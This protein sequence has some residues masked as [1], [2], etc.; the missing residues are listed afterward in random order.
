[1]GAKKELKKRI[2]NLEA[3]LLDLPIMLG[4][5]LRTQLQHLQ[6]P[7]GSSDLARLGLIAT[8]EAATARRTNLV[9][10]LLSEFPIPPGHDAL[11]V[12]EATRL[13][14]WHPGAAQMRLDW[15]D[16]DKP[17]AELVRV[18]WVLVARHGP[19]EINVGEPI[20]GSAFF[21]D[22]VIP[23]VDGGS[24]VYVGGDVM[25]G[26]RVYLDERAQ[27]RILT[28][29]KIVIHHAGATVPAA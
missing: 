17:A 1:M 13:L 25:F 18:Q 3:Q 2:E 20:R 9:P 23:V 11:L 19:V 6:Q 26:A 10:R 24:H 14:S 4:E 7:Q 29:A 8:Q 16:N 27:G 5:V 22:S 28:G 21:G 15:A 12:Q